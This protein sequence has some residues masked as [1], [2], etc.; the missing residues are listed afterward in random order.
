MDPTAGFLACY[1]SLHLSDPGKP[2]GPRTF[3]QF[4]PA[5][6]GMRCSACVAQ[7]DLRV[8]H[9]WETDRVGR[10]LYPGDGGVHW[11]SDGPW[12]SPAALQRL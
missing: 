2:F 1:S 10:S 5:W 3:L 8:P 4:P 12:P 7:R 6:P 9:E 11:P